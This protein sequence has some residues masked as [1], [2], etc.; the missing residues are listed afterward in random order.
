MFTNLVRF[1]IASFAFYQYLNAV[2]ELA[3][4]CYLIAA[5]ILSINMVADI[6]MNK[7]GQ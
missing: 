2:D 5:G 3:K 6:L 7:K 4:L 1:I